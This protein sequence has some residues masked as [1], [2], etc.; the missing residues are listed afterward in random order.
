[1]RSYPKSFPGRVLKQ[2]K[3][4]FGMF[5]MTTTAYYFARY[6][7]KSS[8][9]IIHIEQVDR[10]LV[11]ANSSVPFLRIQAA[12][13]LY[14][15]G[16]ATIKLVMPYY[17]EKQENWPDMSVLVKTLSDLLAKYQYK[18]LTAPAGDSLKDMPSLN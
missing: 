14:R 3:R 8:A 12:E 17:Q 1:M 5:P 7:R 18:I 11:A 4:G 2:L 10:R 16:S 6:K 13:D 15:L 9:I